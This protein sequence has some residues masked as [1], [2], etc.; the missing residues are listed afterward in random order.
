MPELPE[1]EIFKKYIES[2]SL[3]K[4]I[5]KAVVKSSQILETTTENQLKAKLETKKFLL[6]RR[7]GK[8]LFTNVS[9]ELWLVMHFGMTGYLKYFKNLEDEPPHSRLV[10]SFEND[11][12]LAF[13]DQ[14]KF[15]KITTTAKIEGFIR[16]KRLGKDALSLDFQ[17]F[18]EIM[19][20]GR[21]TVKYTLMNQHVIAGIGNIY[22]DEIVF[23]SGIH[24]KTKTAELKNKLL[25]KLFNNMKYVLNTAIVKHAELEKLPKIFCQPTVR[26]GLNVLGAAERCNSSRF[27]AEPHT[28]APAAKDKGRCLPDVTL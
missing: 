7:H 10:L 9:D 13:D 14:R 15:G 8:Y 27:S 6:C 18:K 21:G 17:S 12:H 2:T 3:N 24:P 5:R 19:Q 16:K 28:F 20:A 11:Y 22:S 1:V 4:K 26:K 25:K 23:Q